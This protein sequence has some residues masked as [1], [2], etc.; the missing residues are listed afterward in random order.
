LQ[1][2]IELLTIKPGT[3]NPPEIGAIVAA[4][5]ATSALT[6]RYAAALPCGASLSAIF[7]AQR[8]TPAVDMLA[9][10]LLKRLEMV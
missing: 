3:S 8:L 7:P 1:S 6:A 2:Q 4:A 9:I 10:G 5:P